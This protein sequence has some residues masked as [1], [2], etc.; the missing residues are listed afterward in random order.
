MT[1]VRVGW[2][3]LS[4]C[5]RRLWRLPIRR[6]LKRLAVV[7]ASVV[8]LGAGTVLVLWHRFP[9]RI[10]KLDEAPAS[11]VVTD[12][13]GA[14]LRVYR[15]STDEI[16]VPVSLDEVSPWLA[17]ATIAVEDRGFRDHC[18]VDLSAVARATWQNVLRW[19]VH[20]GASTLTMQVVRMLEPRPRTLWS[21]AVE[22]FHA[23]QIDAWSTKERILEHY[24]NLAPYGGDLR[25]VEAAS[26]RYLGKRARDL[27]LG[28]AALIAGLPQSPS[29][30]RP[31]RHYERALGRR[32]VVLDSML[33]QGAIDEEQ[34]REAIES[35]PVVRRH[36]WPFRAPHFAAIARARAAATPAS[37]GVIVRST[38]DAG[39]Q[40]CVEAHVG[41]ALEELVTRP[42]GVSAAV[43]V[44]DVESGAVRAL[45]GSPGYF[46]ACRPGKVNGALARRSPGSA[47]KP[48]LYALAFDRGVASPTT[49]L[50]DV[51]TSFVGYVPRNYDDVYHGPV[52]ASRALARS[53]NVPA[54]RLERRVG[55]RAFID[56]LRR[57]GMTT[58]D[59]GPRH[60]GLT[61][62]LGGGEVRLLDLTN[63]YAALVR[64]GRHRAPGFLE[65]E[66]V[67]RLTPVFTR[68]TS[69]RVLMALSTPEHLRAA[70]GR[71]GGR[72]GAGGR[73]RAPRSATRRARPSDCETRGRWRSRRAWSSASGWEL[74]V[75]RVVPI[76]SASSA[77]RR[78]PCRSRV[79]CRGANEA[80]GRSPTP[81]SRWR[82]APSAAFR[83]VGT[84]RPGTA[85]CR[86]SPRVACRLAV[87]TAR[88]SSTSTRGW[89]SAR[90]APAVGRHAPRWSRSGRR[91]SSG[92]SGRQAAL[93]HV[94]RTTSPAC[95]LPI[96]GTVRAS[97]HHRTVPATGFS[98]P[99]PSSRRSPSWPRRAPGPR[100]SSGSSTASSTRRSTVPRTSSGSSAPGGTRCVASIREVRGRWRGSSCG[101]S[102]PGGPGRGPEPPRLPRIDQALVGSSPR[103]EC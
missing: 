34:R 97:F 67:R 39:A 98:A 15:S 43:V 3:V 60:Y 33:R 9:F 11:T 38:L 79:S 87:S 14:W 20:S 46:D 53:Y 62:C 73:A 40:S 52:A 70:I 94:A 93:I 22:A 2:S 6:W 54:V 71:G 84:V 90:A 36:P 64:G 74:R 100:T 12:R 99:R 45:L 8:F 95:V 17:A 59:R 63:A 26:R 29:R 56:V 35:R 65:T 10:E 41:R 21:K 7:A 82:S 49:R 18:G 72:A 51:P 96:V 42:D 4:R 80:T 47:L 91:R 32:R 102:D 30:L 24:L 5:V 19:R 48:F 55:T 37:G 76:L 31:D 88:C 13:H 81:S 61:L 27:D 25:G 86:A 83:R 103:V 92:G 1:I 66:R 23:L 101:G 28:E 57:L 75:V 50:A 44:V 68:S 85:P 77:L 58:I 89:R 69:R 78:W 16:R